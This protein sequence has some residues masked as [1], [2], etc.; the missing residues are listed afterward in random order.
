MEKLKLT[1]LGEDSWGRTVYQ[2]ENGNYYKDINMMPLDK[3]PKELCI[4]C[5]RNDF[6]GEPDY[7]VRNFEILNPPTEREIREAQYSGKYML[8][9]RLR[10][11]CNY[12][13]GYGNR[14]ETILWAGNVAD[15][16]AKMKELWHMFPDD[17]KPEWCTLQDIENFE[18]L[19]TETD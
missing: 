8:L 16:I 12:F 5:P 7:P 13:L 17:L 14:S 15:Q 9:S 1:R 11:D 4:S 18:K 19:M 6:E 3:T 10:M 2:D